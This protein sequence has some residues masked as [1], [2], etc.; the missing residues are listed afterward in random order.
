M[1]TMLYKG[2]RN[3]QLLINNRK[4][5]Y[6]FDNHNKIL[7][8][9]VELSITGNNSLN[10]VHIDAH[11]DDAK[12]QNEKREKL[13][14]E[15]VESYI[16]ETRIS[17]FFDALSETKIINKIFPVTHSDSFEFFLP[18]FPSCSLSSQALVFL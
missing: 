4:P 17:D 5:I 18:K 16:K 9:F 3:S 12:F 6:L 14:L 13:T 11:P 1:V 7:Y 10:V 15:E 2:L 8:P